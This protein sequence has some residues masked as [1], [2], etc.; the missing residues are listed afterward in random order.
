MSQFTLFLFPQRSNGAYANGA[1]AATFSAATIRW[2]GGGGRK[3]RGLGAHPA[4]AA[5]AGPR[6]PRLARRLAP[7]PLPP[8][9]PLDAKTPNP[10]PLLPLP[11]PRAR[12]TLCQTRARAVTATPTLNL[13]TFQKDVLLMIIE[14]V[15]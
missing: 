1:A 11:S 10:S 7:T 3:T 13:K 14:N 5:A 15:L 12:R 9:R 2:S 6:R 8:P 4:G